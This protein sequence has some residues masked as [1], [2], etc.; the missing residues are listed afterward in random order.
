MRITNLNQ[1]K[2]G[3]KIK[4]NGYTGTLYKTPALVVALNWRFD[5]DNEKF[6]S[7]SFSDIDFTANTI[8]TIEEPRGLRQMKVGDIVV[9]MNGKCPSKV[10][11]VLSNS[12]LIEIYISSHK[13]EWRTFDDAEELGWHLSEV[14]DGKS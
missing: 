13:A 14:A 4:L 1:L 6:G 12:F 2:D 8:E 3:M 9:G 11:E 5:Y 7:L 10:L